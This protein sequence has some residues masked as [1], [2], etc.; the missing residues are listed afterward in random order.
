MFG[1]IARLMR[2]SGLQEKLETSAP[3]SGKNMLRAMS[4][5]MS[6]DEFSPFS[7]V[8]NAK[9]AGISKPQVRPNVTTR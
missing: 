6:V 9:P 7:N 5:I 8:A 4:P 3:T 2:S 1:F